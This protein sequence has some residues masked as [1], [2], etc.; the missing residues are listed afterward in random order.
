MFEKMRAIYII[1]RT[2]AVLALLPILSLQLSAQEK[3]SLWQ[4]FVNAISAPSLEL[5]PEYVYQ[6]A[7][8]WNVAV[9]ADLRHVGT[10]LTNH[11]STIVELDDQ[12]IDVTADATLRLQGGLDKGIGLQVGYGNLSM[13]YNQ[14]LGVD[15]TYKNTSFSFDYMAPGYAVQVQYFDFRRPMDYEAL[16]DSGILSLDDAGQ[17]EY[18]GRM[19]S[20]IVDAFYAFNRRN[21]AYSAVYKGNVVQ[22]RSAGT[23]MFGAKYIQGMVSTHP[24]EFAS[25]LMMGLTNQTTRQIS[26]GGGLSYNLV[27]YHRQPDE[28]GKGLRNLT[29]NVTAIPMVTLFNQFIT[30]MENEDE[31]FNPI[32]TRSV[33]NGNMLVNYVLKAGAIYTWDRFSV[34]LSGSYDR[35]NYRGASDIPAQYEEFEFEKIHS[36]GWFR[37]WTASLKFCVRF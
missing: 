17:T 33:M 18:P 13:G 15:K 4:K 30:T 14:K 2:V 36:S 9:S 16:I 21:F 1:R 25:Q 34:N 5:D 3:T 23:L 27:P 11:L 26:F 35:Y 37:R 19:T 8:T 28:N 6:P 32:K 12:D 29:F 24:D 7:P 20:F 31:N 10:Y 22:R